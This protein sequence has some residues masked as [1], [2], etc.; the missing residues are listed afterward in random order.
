MPLFS[1]KSK[2]ELS[3]YSYHWFWG[4][5]YKKSVRIDNIVEGLRD[6][7]ETII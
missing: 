4:L 7:N 2:E 1:G 3:H 6:S 5:R